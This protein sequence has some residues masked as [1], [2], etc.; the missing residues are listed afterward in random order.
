[1]DKTSKMSKTHSKDALDADEFLDFLADPNELFY[2]E[3]SAI[4]PTPRINQNNGDVSDIDIL[5]AIDSL[6][7]TLD[8]DSSFPEEH[9]AST[10]LSLLPEKPSELL[11]S[12]TITKP[13]NKGGRP[14]K[15]HPANYGKSLVILPNGSRAYVPPADALM[16]AEHGVEKQSSPGKNSATDRI[17][18]LHFLPDIHTDSVCS[19]LD[20]HA[21]ESKQL[22][23]T[24]PSS[25]SQQA[26]ISPRTVRLQRTFSLEEDIHR[27][28]CED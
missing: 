3:N 4:I 11:P 26:V 25:S 22:W 7:L 9:P 21:R 18:S 13:K 2:D 17:S 6:C 19:S 24:F 14:P 10:K 15:K 1:M 5:D 8:R 16:Y 20:S 12:S 27:T 23:H 28:F